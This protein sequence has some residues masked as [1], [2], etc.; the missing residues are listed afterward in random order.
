M[1]IS[2]HTSL[3]SF[4]IYFNCPKTV[5]SFRLHMTE[6]SNN[7]AFGLSSTPSFNRA[8]YFLA[9]LLTP[10]FHWSHAQ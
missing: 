4:H 5:R 6:Q 10:T 3:L 9:T 1:L 2:N 7:S 8:F